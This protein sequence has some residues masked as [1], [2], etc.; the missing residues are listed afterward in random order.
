MYFSGIDNLLIEENIIYRPSVVNPGNHGIYI[1]RGGNANVITRGNMV[2][3]GK[4]MGNAIMQRPG[5]ISEGNIVAHVRWTGI[6][7]GACNDGGGSDCYDPVSATIINNIVIN[8]SRGIEL[9]NPYIAPNAIVRDN[10]VIN[11]NSDGGQADVGI[12]IPSNAHNSIVENNI[13]YNAWGMRINDSGASSGFTLRNNVI[14]ESQ[15]N[16]PIFSYSL[17]QASTNITAENNRFYSTVR[18][19]SQWFNL[20]NNTS[21]T[22]WQGISGETGS[23]AP[24][25]FTDASRSIATYNSDILG[26]SAD[27]EDF[28]TEAIKQHKFNYRTTYTVE[29]LRDYLKAGFIISQ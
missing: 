16:V 19:A 5:G 24:I 7:F 4:P 8:V 25:N 15:H 17:A 9:S 13:L 3:V 10:L 23:D 29:V 26:R 28:F 27:I 21:F 20:S 11:S 6:A 22:A 14:Y 1:S 12:V 2:H 18:D